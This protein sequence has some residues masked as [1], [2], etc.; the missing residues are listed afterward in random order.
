MSREFYTFNHR[1][2][3]N[4]CRTEAAQR[5]G[6]QSVQVTSQYSLEV[7]HAYSLLG[8]TFIGDQC[9]VFTAVD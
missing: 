6:N 2:R 4:E 7:Q 3:T 8:R 1:K 5:P 9:R